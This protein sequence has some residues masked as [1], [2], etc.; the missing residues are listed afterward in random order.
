MEHLL[1][2]QQSLSNL[3]AGLIIMVCLHF[4]LK[5]GELLFN[6]Y[7]T[8]T[9]VTEKTLQTNSTAL[10]KLES[11]LERMET[12]LDDVLKMRKDFNRIFSGIRALAGDRW[13]AIRKEIM[14]NEPFEP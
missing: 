8:R 12:N 14:Q 9:A 5:I 7:K 3:F 10:T 1:D 4:L 6:V 11:R 2:S 13:P